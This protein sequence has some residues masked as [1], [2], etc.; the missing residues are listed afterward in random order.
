MVKCDGCGGEEHVRRAAMT[1]W[2]GNILDLCL[3]C[4][5][6]LADMIDKI[7]FSPYREKKS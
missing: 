3:T 5:K 1:L 2:N 6:P 7:W 4:W